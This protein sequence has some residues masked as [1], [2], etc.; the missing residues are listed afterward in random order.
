MFL[1]KERNNA[2]LFIQ[3]DVRIAALEALV[4]F[5]QVDGKWE[6]LTFLLD[7]AET[8][9]HPGVRHRLLRIMI[10][11]P[12]FKRNTQ[13]PLDKPELADRIWNLMKYLHLI[14]VDNYRKRLDP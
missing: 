10:D 6:D 4:D 12:P 8:D 5:T 2:K 3:T 7:L 14:L 13:H 9:K 1:D 11:N